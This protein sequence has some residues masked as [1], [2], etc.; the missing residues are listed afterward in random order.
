MFAS[1]GCANRSIPNVDGLRFPGYQS[2][3]CRLNNNSIVEAF[4]PLHKAIDFGTKSEKYPFGYLASAYVWERIEPVVF[5]YV[6]TMKNWIDTKRVF[7]GISIVG[8]KDV[9]TE[10]D[11]YKDFRGKIDR[12]IV[13][14]FPVVIENVEDEESINNAIKRLQIEYI[15]ALGIKSS[16]L[17]NK[18]I[19]E[20]YQ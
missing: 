20:V 9:A 16:E 19:Q 5:Q 14:C 3:E 18:L 8:C 2:E 12:D 17:L 1:M 10:D 7:I 4:Q 11:I 13:I 6:E 15:L